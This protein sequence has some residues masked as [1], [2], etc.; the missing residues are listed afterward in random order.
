MSRK[1]RKTLD[2]FSS[3]SFIAI[4]SLQSKVLAES[5]CYSTAKLGESNRVPKQAYRKTKTK[6][7]KSTHKN[8]RL[9]TKTISLNEICPDQ[10]PG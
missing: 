10:D 5:V 6:V 3:K 4:Y 9:L 7:P 8:H 2:R 1:E